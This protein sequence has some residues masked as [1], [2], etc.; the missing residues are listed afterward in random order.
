MIGYG[1]QPFF[2]EGT[3]PFDMHRKLAATLDRCMEIIAE[4]QQSARAGSSADSAAAAAAVAKDV[5]Q[6]RKTER[7]S[8]NEREHER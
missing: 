7:Q 2:V 8:G 6:L 4:I 1:H 3:D 5:V